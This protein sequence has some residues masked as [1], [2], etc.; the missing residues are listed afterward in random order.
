MAK[1]CKDQLDPMSGTIALLV[2]SIGALIFLGT[3]VAFTGLR[4]S[5]SNPNYDCYAKV[6]CNR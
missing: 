3:V 4:D 2:T 6:Q 1:P 5:S